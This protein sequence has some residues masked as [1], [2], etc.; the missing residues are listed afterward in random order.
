MSQAPPQAM[1]KG[2]IVSQDEAVIY[3]QG[4]VDDNHFS[5][6]TLGQHA[7]T[8]QDMALS[9]PHGIFDAMDISTF[10]SA[11]DRMATPFL[12]DMSLTDPAIPLN[13]QYSNPFSLTYFQHVH[14]FF[15]FLDPASYSR[16]FD[17]VYGDHGFHQTLDIPIATARFHIYI[18]QAI[19]ARIL[20]HHNAGQQSFRESFFS[21]AM[22][23]YN[24][25]QKLDTI[26]DIHS[27]L[28]LL[29]YSL[30]CETIEIEP[31]TLKSAITS[32]CVHLGLHKPRRDTGPYTDEDYRPH[33]T[34]LSAY[35]LDRTISLALDEPFSLCDDNIEIE[36][37][38]A[39]LEIHQQQHNSYPFAGGTTRNFYT[40]SM[41]AKLN[42][43]ISTICTVQ[44]LTRPNAQG[45]PRLTV[46]FLTTPTPPT[47]RA[48]RHEIL[49]TVHA[50]SAESRDTDSTSQSVNVNDVLELLINEGTLLLLHPSSG[51][52]DAA[53][54]WV[55]QSTARRSVGIYRRLQ[56]SEALVPCVHLA[57]GVYFCGMVLQGAGTGIGDA[58]TKGG[59][60]SGSRGRSSR[61]VTASGMTEDPDV[62]LCRDILRWFGEEGVNIAETFKEALDESMA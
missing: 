4:Q 22:L 13:Q 50:L 21:A 52:L 31:L 18:V 34:F 55:A 48:W 2:S 3:Q 41:A 28:L 11:P 40:L 8:S 17:A 42:R 1:V 44:T 5:V 45:I 59:G 15:P 60:A 54:R 25:F 35:I 62:V 7:F 26:H 30:F 53:E 47:L 12:D 43:I 29:I 39:Q 46:P 51:T 58:E 61:R 20:E 38:V 23:S 36:E 14:P 19:G 56:G 6:D 27:A 33:R 10:E 57:R 24:F 16:Q 49:Q 37:L 9:I 32:S